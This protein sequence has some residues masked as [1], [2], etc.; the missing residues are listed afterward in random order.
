[1]WNL[2]KITLLVGLGAYGGL[3]MLMRILEPRLIYFPRKEL[4]ATPYDEGLAFQSVSFTTSDGVQLFGWFIP[5]GD[6][7]STVLFCHGNGGNISHRIESIRLFHRLGLSTFI[8]DYRG[9]GLSEGQPTEQGTYLDAEAA[10]Q[11]LIQ[12]EGYAPSDIVLFGRSLG[13]AIA[14]RLAHRHAAAGLIVESAFTSVRDIGSQMYPYLPVRLLSRFDYNTKTWI[15]KTNCPIL[16]VHSP[17]DEMIPFSHG[18]RL[19]D[20]AP[21]PK[22]F[23]E[24]SGSHNS[25]YLDSGPV[26]EEG[27]N[28]FISAILHDG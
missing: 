9:Y 8:F 10:W 1:M 20:A 2:I 27:L 4:V 17:D 28:S 7:N 12:T 3:L 13:G 24:I 16:I 18:Q 26:Y 22:Q 11:Y 21:A 15:E 25:G 6:P 23:L 14:A 5:A 19:F